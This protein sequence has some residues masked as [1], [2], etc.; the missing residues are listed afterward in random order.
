MIQYSISVARSDSLDG[1][2]HLVGAVVAGDDGE[3]SSEWDGATD[4]GDA[5]LGKVTDALMA[6]ADAMDA[7][8]LHPPD[9]SE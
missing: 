5:K 2:A 4:V 8:T 9:G 1:R 3:L 6:L 7:L